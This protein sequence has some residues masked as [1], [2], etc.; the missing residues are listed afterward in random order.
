MFKSLLS[1]FF[2]GIL[3]LFVL[4]TLT[5]FLC[6]ALP[7]GPF[8]SEKARPKHIVAKMEE[9]YGFNKPLGEQYVRRIKHYLHGDLGVSIRLEGRP[10]IEVISQA[11]P[12]SFQL[13][14]V[15]MIIA[16]IVGIPAGC[17]AA[18]KRNSLIDTGTMLIA[19]IGICLPA[20]VIGPLLAEV[21]G[22]TLKWFPALGWNP[23]L[24]STWI[25]PGITLGLAYAAYLSRLTRAGMLETLSQDFVRTARAKGVSPWNIIVRHCL[26]GGLIPAVAYL[27]PAFAGI[28]SGSVVIEAVFQIPG[29]GRQFIKAI[30]S[31]DEAM[32]F[33]PVLLFGTLVILANLVTDIL[34][35][36]LNP[37]LRKS[38]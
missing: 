21:F 23:A 33:G 36:W 30:E 22:R 7:G 4:F 1:R 15:A 35:V 9:Y 13:G 19:M 32:I 2:Q 38:S 14:V 8:Q 25:L 12:V 28:I 18:A 27:G 20:F 31:H 34:G 17:L 3:V 11:F 37:R 26:R 29:L 16:V 24:P 6:K 5:F 10:V